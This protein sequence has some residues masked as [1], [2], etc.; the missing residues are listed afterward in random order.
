ML[1][2]L[3][4]VGIAAMSLLWTAALLLAPATL[5]GQKSQ[6]SWRA[7]A[8]VYAIGAG[9]CHQRPERSFH[10]AGVQWPVCARC[11]GLYAGGTAGLLAWPM[12]RRLRRRKGAATAVGE[13][14]LERYH[15]RRR[16]RFIVAV[17][18][19]TVVTALTA[20]AGLF[21]PGNAW[22]ALLAL[23]LG[24]LAGGA[25]AAVLLGDLR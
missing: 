7:A 2:R 21:D 3:G 22:R 20:L 4:L 1:S 16:R 12:A 5:V 6:P 13:S 25:L 18:A 17:A 24:A 10:T 15:V 23:P 19:P 14:D 8:L 11:T 9:V